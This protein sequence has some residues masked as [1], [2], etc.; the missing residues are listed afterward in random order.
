[1]CGSIPLQSGREARQNIEQG[2]S[3]QI[4]KGHAQ[5]LCVVEIGKRQRR[6]L[7]TRQQLLISNRAL[8]FRLARAWAMQAAV[9][10]A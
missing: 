6:I 10:A 7:E 3:P 9:A 8:H 5:M 1:M 2:I 4:K